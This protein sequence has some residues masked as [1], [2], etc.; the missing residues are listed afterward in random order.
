MEEVWAGEER[1]TSSVHT[2]YKATRLGE[3]LETECR[4]KVT[5]SPT[6]VGE[7]GGKS[8]GETRNQG[9]V[10]WKPGRMFQGGGQ[11]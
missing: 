3:L 5:L 9:N 4:Q 1:L 7:M 11:E 10:M 6:D 2:E 8:Q